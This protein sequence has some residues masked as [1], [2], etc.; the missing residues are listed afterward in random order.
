MLSEKR[1]LYDILLIQ[2]FVFKLFAIFHSSTG[3]TVVL[4]TSAG[5]SP[6][7]GSGKGLRCMF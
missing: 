4:K 6:C 7:V 3:F 1:D 2:T 5:Y